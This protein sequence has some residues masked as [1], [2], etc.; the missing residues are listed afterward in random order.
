MVADCLFRR[1]VRS[2]KHYKV[3]NLVGNCYVINIRGIGYSRSMAVSCV[4]DSDGI[5]LGASERSIDTT[6]LSTFASLDYFLPRTLFA[7][8]S[9]PERFRSVQA[10]SFQSQAF[11]LVSIS[12]YITFLERQSVS[13]CISV[14]WRAH[15][16][17]SSASKSL[18]IST[19]TSHRSASIHF[20]FL[21]LS[22]PSLL[23]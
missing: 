3:F 14:G 16:L 7:S 4:I 11:A 20:N 17:V 2:C 15:Q 8:N 12:V 9:P 22:G 13:P 18:S 19:L 5:S 21:R 10:Y 23:T 1:A 6:T